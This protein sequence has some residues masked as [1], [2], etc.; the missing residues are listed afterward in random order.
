M[1]NKMILVDTSKCTGCKACSVACKEW[2]D[3]P[4]EKTSLIKSYQSTKD[5]TPNTLT[6]VTFDEKYEDKNML[7]LMRKNQC[8]HCEDPACMKACSSN[9]ITKTDAGFVVIDQDK[10][11]GCGQCEQFCPFGIPKVDKIANKSYKCSG[12]ADRVENNL[13]PACVSTCQT[14][15]LEFGDK[16]AMM[17]KAKQRLVEVQKKYPKASIYGDKIMGGTT[18]TYLLLDAP[19]E[20]GLPINPSMPLSLILWKDVIQP[21]GVI[22]VGGAAAAVAVGVIANTVKGN[23]KGD[24][25]DHEKQEIGGKL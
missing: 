1:T 18:Y 20:Y 12:C 22:G 21:L 11:I 13:N 17:S 15:A 14:G 7:W 24:P 8:F 2:N 19:Q 3:L 16:D 5:F 10:C 6:Y 25:F 4:A 23:Y 9:G